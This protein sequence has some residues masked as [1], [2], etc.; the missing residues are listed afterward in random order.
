MKHVMP[1]DLPPELAK[2]AAEKAFDA[3]RERF[4]KY[5]PTLTWVSETQAEAT[6]SA[7]GIILVGNMYLR[8]TEIAFELDVP[9]VFGMF[10][11]K[12]MEIMERELRIWVAKAKAGEI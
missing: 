12:A 1:H 7:K 3:Y 2:K 6:F 11:K 5:D 9:F 4:A 10:R 8:P